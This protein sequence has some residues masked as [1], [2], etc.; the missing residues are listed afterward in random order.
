MV[1]FSYKKSASKQQQTR[2]HEHGATMVEFSIIAALL[3][4]IL[5]GI[6]EFAIIFMQEHFV[7]NAAREGI[8]IGVR[9]NNYDC[10][11]GAPDDAHAGASCG[12][13]SKHRSFHIEDQIRA[14]LSTVYE[15]SDPTIVKVNVYSEYLD[16]VN[17]ENPAL[18]VTV[19]TPN[20]YPP[21]ISN[22]VKA[23]LHRGPGGGTLATPGTIYFETIMEYEDPEEYH[24]AARPGS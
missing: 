24:S 22:L 9:A 20:F 4:V 3:I 7:A 2:D 6:L 14:Y 12:L 19:E 11:S 5:F 8:R 10:W 18:I 16:T 21:I 17:S 1:P 13:R 23:L 15:S